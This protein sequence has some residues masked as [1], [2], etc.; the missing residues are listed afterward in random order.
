MFVVGV[1]L[2]ATTTL[3]TGG[4]AFFYLLFTGYRYHGTHQG[5]RGTYWHIAAPEFRW[6]LAAEYLVSFIDREPTEV[7]P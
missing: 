4:L 6:C 1:A 5:G 2:Q 7:A 3:F